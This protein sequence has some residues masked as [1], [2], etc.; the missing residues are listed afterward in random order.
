MT[1]KV[2]LCLR[3][4]SEENKLYPQTR[5]EKIFFLLL[6]FQDFFDEEGFFDALNKKCF[7]ESAFTK[8]LLSLI[9]L[10]LLLCLVPRRKDEE[11]R[12]RTLWRL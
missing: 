4:K 2:A 8:L 9:F 3:E 1:L 12:R 5:E 10:L 7:S 6:G 11:R